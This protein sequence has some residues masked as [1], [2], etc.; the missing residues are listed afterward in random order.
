M[1]LSGVLIH[2]LVLR[3]SK[4]INTPSNNIITWLLVYS[5]FHKVKGHYTYI[6]AHALL[7]WL[8]CLLH[9]Y[10]HSS[11]RLLVPSFPVD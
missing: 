6:I 11:V 2:M 10:M 4:C 1:L 3:A 5:L 9:L 8:E 7:N